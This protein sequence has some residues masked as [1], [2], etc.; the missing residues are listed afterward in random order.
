MLLIDHTSPDVAKL[1]CRRGGKVS[2]SCERLRTRTVILELTTVP[3]R[4]RVLPGSGWKI[5]S[6]WKPSQACP[7]KRFFL[8]LCIPALA[9]VMKSPCKEYLSFLKGYPIK[10]PS[11][12]S[13]LRTKALKNIIHRLTQINSKEDIY[14][15]CYLYLGHLRIVSQD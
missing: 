5:G 1:L 13:Q 11:R 9:V 3:G 8:A 15:N 14:T 4:D 2:H 7:E 6:L 10:S 12:D